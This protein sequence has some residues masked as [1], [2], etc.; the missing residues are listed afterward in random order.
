M[1]AVLPD[2]NVDDVDVGPIPSHELT[3]ASYLHGSASVSANSHTRD[4]MQRDTRGKSL[5][6]LH[7]SFVSV[8][9]GSVH[10]RIGTE[11]EEVLF[12]EVHSHAHDT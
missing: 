5:D 12:L 4:A 1:P 11:E 6:T 2:S 7:V 3:G 8:F 9:Q 10:I